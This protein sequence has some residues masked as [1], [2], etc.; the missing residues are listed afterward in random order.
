MSDLGF[1]NTAYAPVSELEPYYSEG[2]YSELIEQAT[3]AELETWIKSKGISK[4]Q[5]SAYN[6]NG[7]S[8]SDIAYDLEKM[9]YSYPN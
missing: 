5:I 7:Y 9:G 4:R 1:Y 3:D 8:Y 2:S 6:L